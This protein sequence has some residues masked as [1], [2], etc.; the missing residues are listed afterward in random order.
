VEIVERL[1]LAAKTFA[2]ALG[3]KRSEEI[4]RDSEARLNLAADSAEAGLWVLD[5]N[6]RAFWVTDRT[7][8]IF[9]YG[10]GEVITLERFEASVLPEDLEIVQQTIERSKH[11]RDLLNVQFRILRGDGCVRWVDAR[12]RPYFTASG[13]PERLMGVTVDITDR[14][15]MEE[16]SRASEA[17]LSSGVDLAGLGFFEI[18]FGEGI[19]YLD[20]RARTLFGFPAGVDHGAPAVQFWEEHLHPDDRQDLLN[21]RTQLRDEGADRISKEYRYL[22]P[23]LGLRWLHHLS[24]IDIRDA[25]GKAVHLIGVCR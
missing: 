8:A 4:L 3:R 12:G 10:P 14:R 5:W 17:R 21:A 11:E 24:R 23:D 13:E 20:E 7:R 25:C 1:Q 22:H 15:R 6:A 19:T 18:V 16:A 2:N 9:G